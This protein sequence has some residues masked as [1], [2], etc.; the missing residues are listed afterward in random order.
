MRDTWDAVFLSLVY[1]DL[2]KET[3]LSERQVNLLRWE[4]IRDRKVVTRYG[5]EVMLS[6]ELCNA[7]ALLSKPKDG[8]GFVFIGHKMCND[9][10]DDL[11]ESVEKSDRHRCKFRFAGKWLKRVDF[12]ERSC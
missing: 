11:Q 10:L 8:R 9:F 4:Q 3:R 7:L 5:R 12:V 2:V 1:R 6:R